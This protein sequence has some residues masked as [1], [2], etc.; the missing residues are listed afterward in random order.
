MKFGFASEIVD[1]H[2]NPKYEHAVTVLAPRKKRM[3]DRGYWE[4]IPM[5]T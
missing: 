3:R 2:E 5:T 1:R 4:F